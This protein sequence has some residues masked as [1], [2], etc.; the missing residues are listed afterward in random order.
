MGNF[1]MTIDIQNVFI[2]ENFHKI[3]FLGEVF[4]THQ[5][6]VGSCAVDNVI[7]DTEIQKREKHILLKHRGILYT[8]SE[9]YQDKYIFL[10]DNICILTDE[11]IKCEVVDKEL[12]EKIMF[13][14]ENYVF[15]GYSR[16]P[17]YLKYNGIIKGNY[18]LDPITIFTER[19]DVTRF[20]TAIAMPFTVINCDKEKLEE[21]ILCETKGV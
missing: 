13:K 4:R 18:D 9:Y 20:R 2:E 19:D 3:K 1:N 7:C 8:L 14:G 11:N 16:E 12:Y 6:E 21:I 15:F 10:E 17:I 5:R